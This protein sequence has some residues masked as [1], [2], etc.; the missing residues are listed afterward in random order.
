MPNSG[1]KEAAEAVLRELPSVV[2]AFV[3]ED[4][5]GHPR[6]VHLLIR[7]GPRPRDLAR[8]V[9]DLL[10]ERLGIPVDQRVISIAQLST[11]AAEAWGVEQEAQAPHLRLEYADAVFD[12]EPE[13]LEPRAG[14]V[15]FTG[16]E[17]NVSAGRVRVRVHVD[18]GGAE[19]LGEA[20]ELMGGGGRVRAAANAMLDA[21]QRA[22]PTMR[23]ELEGAST[24]RA[25]D[26]DYVMV[27]ALA[28]APQLGRR[29]VR[30]VGAHPIEDDEDTAAALATL[31]ALNRTFARVLADAP[32]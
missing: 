27:A 5:N 28:S 23:L 14:R 3:R 8:D 2:G 9:R 12:P 16:A 24:V 13:L 11:D 17:A 31:K 21:A 10:E 30:L 7:P 29:P 20:V 1:T 32:R 19:Y 26:R 18:L 22:A 4:V 6:E 25:L 15:R